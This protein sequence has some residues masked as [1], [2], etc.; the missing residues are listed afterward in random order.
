MDI[1]LDFS[2]IVYVLFA[3]AVGLGIP[4]YLMKNDRLYAAVGSIIA[5]VVIFIYFGMRWFDGMRLKDNL[6][7]GLSKNTKWPPQIN[8]CPDFLSLKQVGTRYFCVDAMGVSSLPRFTKD[9]AIDTTGT[10][11]VNY[12]EIQKDKTAQSYA[13]SNFTGGPTAGL[14]WEGV[15]DGMTASNII[16]PFP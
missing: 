3:F 7:G 10:S 8:Y 14:T 9:S 12:L 2:F 1:G 4:F 6:V 15:Y 11:A 13:V 16:P 5:A